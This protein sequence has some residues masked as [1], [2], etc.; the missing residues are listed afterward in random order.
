MFN[1][2]VKIRGM[3]ESDLPGVKEIDRQL[4]G[5]GRASSWPASV[6]TEWSASV[7]RP[8]LSF[9]A[10]LGNEVVGFLLGDIRG[11]EYGTSTSG[12]IDMMG[13][14]PEHQHRGIGQRLVEAFCDECRKNQVKAQVIIRDD[15][16]QLIGFWASVGFKKGNLVSYER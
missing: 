6:E 7:Y 13:V 15:D 1:G 16:Q 14:A 11:A 3:S 4:V 5:E 12:W 10:Q 9:V 2:E 8:A